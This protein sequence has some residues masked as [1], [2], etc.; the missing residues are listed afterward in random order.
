MDPTQPANASSDHASLVPGGAVAN[1]ANNAENVW[2][3]ERIEKA[4]KTLKEMHIQV[5]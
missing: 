4:L 3:E 5:R 1:A 2:D